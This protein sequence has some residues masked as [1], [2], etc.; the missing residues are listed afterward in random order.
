MTDVQHEHVHWPCYY[1]GQ[2]VDVDDPGPETTFFLLEGQERA[3]YGHGLG[4]VCAKC[5]ARRRAGE[6]LVRGG[7]PRTS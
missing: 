5:D 3:E 1:C 4:A 7:G 6:K 2:P